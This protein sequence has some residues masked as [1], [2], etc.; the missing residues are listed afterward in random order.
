MSPGGKKRLFVPAEQMSILGLFRRACLDMAF[1]SGGQPI[2][3]WI[4]RFEVWCASQPVGKHKELQNECVWLRE[5]LHHTVPGEYNPGT[6]VDTLFGR[7][8]GF[9]STAP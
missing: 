4:N 8:E 1:P 5:I 7:H 6:Q 9:A 2:L 3:E